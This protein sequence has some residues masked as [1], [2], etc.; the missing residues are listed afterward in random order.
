MNNEFNFCN[1][2]VFL[3]LFYIII[4][5]FISNSLT[6]TSESYFLKENWLEIFHKKKISPFVC[7]F[8]FIYMVDSFSFLELKSEI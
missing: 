2:D 3:V 8:I 6:K 1:S 4:L 5:Y 7:K